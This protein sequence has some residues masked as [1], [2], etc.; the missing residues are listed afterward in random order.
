MSLGVPTTMQI[1]ADQSTCPAC[2][3][4]GLEIVP[5]LHHM[6][7]AY[8]GPL[9]DFVPTDNG[10]VC[11]KCRRDIVSNDPACE[12]VGQSARCIRCGKETVVSPPPVSPQEQ[13]ER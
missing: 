1:D 4:E 3:A 6:I 10:Y 8:F 5:V 2:G 11:P 12:I 13:I 7:C 9:Y